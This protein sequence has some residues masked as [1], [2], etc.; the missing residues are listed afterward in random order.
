MISRPTYR[1]LTRPEAEIDILEATRWYGGHERGLGREFLRA[2][3]A[4]TAP[5]RRNP[6]LY[7]IVEGEARRLL[8]RRFPYAIIYEIHGSDVVILACLHFSRDPQD[9]ERRLSGGKD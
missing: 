8:L 2:L 5:L 6:L 7:Q 4:A 9:W 3:R 1:L